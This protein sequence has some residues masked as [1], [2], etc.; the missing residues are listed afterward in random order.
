MLLTGLHDNNYLRHFSRLPR[1][2]RKAQTI[3][4]ILTR[5]AV[6]SLET[7]GEEP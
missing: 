2:V 1:G 3:I 7:A 6:K 4:R 5:T